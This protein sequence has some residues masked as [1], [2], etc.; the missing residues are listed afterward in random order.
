MA[1]TQLT[2]HQRQDSGCCALS[3]FSSSWHSTDRGVGRGGHRG[4]TCHQRHRPAGHYNTQS[5]DVS[6]M[7]VNVLQRT[8]CYGAIKVLRNAFFLET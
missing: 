1:T 5:D 4:Q 7:T 3:V 2:F 6:S 8:V